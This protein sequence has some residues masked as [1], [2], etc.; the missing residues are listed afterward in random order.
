MSSNFGIIK[1]NLKTKISFVYDQKSGLVS[2]EF[3]DNA[4]LKLGNNK[5]YY[6]GPSGITYFDTKKLPVNKY[7]PQVILTDFKIAN[8]SIV[9]DIAEKSNIRIKK[10]AYEVTELK[11]SYKDKLVLIEFITL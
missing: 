5:F 10:P 3:N 11:L 4:F 6:G 1:Y 8:K 2:N 9:M 7:S